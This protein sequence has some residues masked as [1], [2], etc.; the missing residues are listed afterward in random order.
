MDWF[1]FKKLDEQFE[2]EAEKEVLEWLKKYFYSAFPKLNETEWRIL[3]AKLISDQVKLKHE[4]NLGIQSARVQ[5]Q[6]IDHQR[7]IIK[8]LQAKLN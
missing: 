2:A 5:E 3:L 7:E 4:K 1:D 8:N 6:T